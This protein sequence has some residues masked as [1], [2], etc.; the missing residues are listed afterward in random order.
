MFHACGISRIINTILQV[1][2]YVKPYA[3]L[4][5]RIRVVR[6]HNTPSL[7]QWHFLGPDFTHNITMTNSGSILEHELT[8]DISY[9]ASRVSYGVPSV[10]VVEKSD[11]VMKQFDCN[12]FDF[13]I[14]QD[15]DECV[16]D[17]CINGGNCTDAEAGYTC[18]CPVGW[19]SIH[20]HVGEYLSYVHNKYVV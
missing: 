12:S 10:S 3:P 5:R 6:L 14:T 18:T 15:M 8:L 11:R 1:S 20:C 13:L 17:P 16:S 7:M 9:L 2:G 19:E 4:E